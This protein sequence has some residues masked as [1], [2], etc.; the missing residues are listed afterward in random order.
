MDDAKITKTLMST[1]AHISWYGGTPL[2]DLTQFKRILRDLQYYVF[3]K[4]NIAFFVN[5][6][7]QFLHAP[8]YAHWVALK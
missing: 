6:F 3:T 5:K 1:S 7:C 8:T 2:N 4:S